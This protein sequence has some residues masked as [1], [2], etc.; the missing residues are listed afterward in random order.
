VLRARGGLGAFGGLPPLG[1][2]L[3][4]TAFVTAWLT[5]VLAM[6]A[7]RGTPVPASLECAWPLRNHAL[8]TCVSQ[9]IYLQAGATI[10]RSFASALM[11]F[12]FAHCAAALS[13]VLRRSAPRG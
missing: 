1:M 4:P 2:V 9:D 7:N 12:F 11:G 5:E 3:F 8:V 6:R 10:Q 13:E